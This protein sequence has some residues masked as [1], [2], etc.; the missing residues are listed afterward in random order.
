MKYVFSQLVDMVKVQ[1]MMDQLYKATGILTALLDLEGNILTASGWRHICLDFHRKHPSTNQ[2]CRLSDRS[3]NQALKEEQ[4]YIIY[5]CD[6]GLTDA[7]TRVM[8]QGEHVATV[9]TGQVFLEAPDIDF[10]RRQ[11]SE[12]GFEEEAY[13]EA[14]KKVPVCDKNQLKNTIEF[15]CSLAEMLGEIGY[16]EIETRQASLELQQTC[17]EL[18]NTKEVLTG[19]L[20]ALRDQYAELH[21]KEQIARQHEELW[22]YAVEG[23][24]L[25]IYDWNVQ[26]NQLFF[27]R[28]YKALLGFEATEFI[29][30]RDEYLR[31]VHPEDR[32]RVK[33]VTAETLA[34]QSDHYLN[35]YRIQNR[36]GSYIWVRAKGKIVARN[37]KKQPLRLVGTLTEITEFKEQ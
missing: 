33:K 8:V 37:E 3:I 36:E 26:S 25:I 14:L 18:E 5:T 7:A 13:L 9:Y 2:R 30:D 15:L 24:G 27:T 1:Q 29:G 28:T 31:R 12:C 10:F 17:E 6:N 35:D 20:E 23:T 22:E 4:P 21:T 11:A 34:G 16:Q 19:T 32:E